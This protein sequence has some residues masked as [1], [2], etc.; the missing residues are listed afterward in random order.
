MKKNILYVVIAV[1]LSAAIVSCSD[2]WL[3][4]SPSDAL[5]RDEVVGGSLRDVFVALNGMYNAIQ[6]TSTHNTYYGARLLYFGDV[7]GDDMQARAAS[8]RSGPTYLMQYTLGNAPVIWNVPYMVI[9]RS[10]NFLNILEKA[11][12]TDASD[13]ILA[14]MRGQALTARALAHFDL[15]RVVSKPYTIAGA[16]GMGVPLIIELPDPTKPAS[17][18]TIGEVY[19]QVIKDLTEAIDLMLKSRV[20]VAPYTGNSRGYFNH[21]SA[22]ALLARVHLYMGNN[23]E[24][25]KVAVD[26]INNS[27]YNLATLSL[28]IAARYDNDGKLIT[29]AKIGQWGTQITPEVLFEV[30]NH[31][32]SSW[33]DRESTG[34]LMSEL[35]YADYLATKTFLD[36]M[37]AE[38]KDDVR[39]GVMLASTGV[40]TGSWGNNRVWVNKFPGR[41]DIRVNN[42]PILRLSEVYLIAAEAAYKESNSAS[43][44]KYLNAIVLRG[45]PSAVPVAEAD[46]TLD[47]I[48]Q[49]RRVEFVGEGHRFFDLMRNNKTVVRYTNDADMGWHLALIAASRSFD[50]NYFRAILPIPEVEISANPNIQSQQN[51][52]Y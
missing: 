22:K 36:L 15:L 23:A 48:L 18:S 30:V 3:D 51:P 32:M 19:A 26:I 39:W 34:Y 4:R 2:N 7:R 21:W 12:I 25:Y 45:N 46:A 49:E 38:Y 9:N 10:N 44:A 28:D 37:T 24:A 27:G 43:A 42:I 31:D 16:S 6:G 1:F 47:R 29:P 35:G 11:N 5:S 8:M 50:V 14:D 17:R 33:V 13:E 41:P 20:G 40:I 52:G